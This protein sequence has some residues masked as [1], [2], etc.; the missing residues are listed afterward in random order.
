MFICYN[1]MVFQVIPIDNPISQLIG[2]HN[3]T[4]ETNLFSEFNIFNCS[5]G[6]QPLDLCYLQRFSWS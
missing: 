3:L 6:I 5:R 2:M 1:I 4:N